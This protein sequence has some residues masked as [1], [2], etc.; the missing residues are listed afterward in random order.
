MVDDLQRKCLDQPKPTPVTGP[1]ATERK[2]NAKDG[3]YYV[4]IPDGSFQMGCSG[5]GE[6]KP[7]EKPPHQVRIGKGFWMGET[8]VTQEAYAKVTGGKRPS[9]CN[10]SRSFP[11]NFSHCFPP[12]WALSVS[13]GASRTRSGGEEFG[14]PRG[15]SSRWNAQ[16]LGSGTSP[17]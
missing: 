12:S 4:W 6:C 16:G 7:D 14:A 2:Q 5:E 8:E 9:N 13:H 11:L 15:R 3:L 17:P 1:K 10:G